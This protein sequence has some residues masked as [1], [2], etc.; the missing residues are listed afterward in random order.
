VLSVHG[1]IRTAK[2]NTMQNIRK[3]YQ[4]QQHH[5]HHQQQQQHQQAQN[6]NNNN[7][8]EPFGSKQK[9]KMD[10][11]MQECLIQIQTME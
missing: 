9:A 8:K 6:H 3:Y 1:S 11:E 7:D 10:R 5:H 2:R 4:Q